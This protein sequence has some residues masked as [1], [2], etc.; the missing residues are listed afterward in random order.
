MV[1]MNHLESSVLVTLLY[2]SGLKPPIPSEVYNSL[3][4]YNMTYISHKLF[5][6]VKILKK[7]IKVT[8]S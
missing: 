7:L 6:N 8:F 5:F 1:Y 4:Y 2:S 3:E